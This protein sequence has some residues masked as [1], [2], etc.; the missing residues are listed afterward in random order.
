MMFQDRYIAG[1]LL[2]EKLAEYKFNNPLVLGIPR[3]AVPMAAIIAEKLGGDLDVV[4][5]RKIGAPLNPEYAIGSVA[6]SG[7]VDIRHEAAEMAGAD[8][9]YLRGEIANQMELIR[10][11]RAMYTKACPQ[12]ELKN[13]DV[14][15]VDDGIATGST[16]L[17]AVRALKEQC[18]KR[19]F[20]AAAVAAPDSIEKLSKETDGVFVLMA[21]DNFM[22]VGQYFVEFDQV[23]DREV[24]EILQKSVKT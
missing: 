10:T 24:V 18:P 9:P 7:A 1:Q 22:A 13:R 23:S 15:I 21:P 3:G 8:E 17:S 14:I 12:I 4:L 2:A 19:I 16:F 5:V 11:R 20:V 6:E